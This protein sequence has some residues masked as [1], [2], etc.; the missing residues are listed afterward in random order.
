MRGP[1]GV[2]KKLRICCELCGYEGEVGA[3]IEG[4]AP[5]AAD[6]RRLDDRHEYCEV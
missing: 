5:L 4:M 6:E 1:W 3:I 2:G